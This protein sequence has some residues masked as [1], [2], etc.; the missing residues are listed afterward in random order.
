MKKT[1][2]RK[3]AISLAFLQLFTSGLLFNKNKGNEKVIGPKSTPTNYV[4]VDNN[5]VPIYQK[6]NMETGA[7]ETISIFD[8]DN[9]A[10]KQYGANQRVFSTR[11]E[12]LLEDPLILEELQKYFPME[13]FECEEDAMFFYRKYLFIIHYNGCGYAAAADYV[14]QLFEG[15]E[16]EF[17]KAFGYPMYTYKNGKIDFNYEIF[18]LKFFNYY[19][20][21]IKK[22]YD[23]VNKWILKEFYE[24]QAIRIAGDN[25]FR[26]PYRN[27]DLTDEE[28]NE[29][30]RLETEHEAHL[31][32]VAIKSRS[33][34]KERV[35]MGIYINASY[36]HLYKY[37]A[38]F[39]IVLD[40]YYKD[41]F[42]EYNV[43][44]IVASDKFILYKINKDGEVE[45][46][47]KY[48]DWHYV[49]VTEVGD[50]II[51]SSWGEK[52]I[53]NNAIAT[54]TDKVILKAH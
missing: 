34:K 26:D 43:N 53:Y 12:E 54:D 29:F 51:V 2:T 40:T 46:G 39:G 24:H 28:W 38:K 45:E 30:K 42:K 25:S 52:F 16:E 33:L 18:M 9:I 36:G 41:K 19:N 31:K 7:L 8:D 32:E 5:N 13:K 21:D 3:I 1:I 17:Y 10:S 15:R 37:L 6:Q 14:F 20:L 50:Q 22:A 49:Y 11:Y 4:L 27:R 23:S 47:Q 35:N 44:D 48:N